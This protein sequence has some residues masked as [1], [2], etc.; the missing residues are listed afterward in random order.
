[1]DAAYAGL[2]GAELLRQ[3]EAGIIVPPDDYLPRVRELCT[4]HDVLMVV[5]EVQSGL[6]RTGTTL[7]CGRIDLRRFLIA[8]K[9]TDF[10][11]N[12]TMPMVD[13]ALA[14]AILA[15][16]PMSTARFTAMVDSIVA[17]WAPDAIR[18]RKER[19]KGDR[20]VTI[21]PDRFTPGQSRISG[22]LPNAD[23]AEFDARLTAMATAVHAGD[24]RKLA[25]RRVD[26]LKALARG[27][28]S[29]ACEC[30]D[31]RPAAMDIEAD[32]TGD[33]DAATVDTADH[34][35]EAPA[36][37][38]G[39]D[40][41]DTPD[42]DT[43]VADPPGPDASPSPISRRPSTSPPRPSAAISTSSPRDTITSRRL[44]RELS[45]SSTAARS[46]GFNAIHFSC[47]E[48]ARAAA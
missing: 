23:A 13:A 27:E 17:K 34:T 44:A 7:A 26:A 19:V 18:R 30:D 8:L 28:A 2:D 21:T 37:H 42:S 47:A 3:G 25:N 1:M 9:R 41:T 20:K 39:N 5:D 11:D 45:I 38:S 31:C 40:D 33:V 22:T 15:R 6:G 12:A 43:V 10:V 4:A 35:T 46:E 29:I 48:T 24:P 36:R 14:E 32:T 16:D